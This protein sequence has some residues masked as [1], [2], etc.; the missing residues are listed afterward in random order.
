[1]LGGDSW[2]GVT[3]LCDKRWGWEYGSGGPGAPPL[4]SR[5]GSAPSVDG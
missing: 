5:D 4:A 1:M 3:D 2:G